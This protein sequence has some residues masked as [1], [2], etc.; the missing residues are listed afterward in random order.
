MRIHA[1]VFPLLLGLAG[2]ASTGSTM[3]AADAPR[4]LPAAG[5]VSVDWTDPA[6]FSEIAAS[7]NRSEAARGDWLNQLAVYMRESAQ[8]AL[9]DGQQLQL[10]IVDVQRAGRNEP[11]QGPEHQNIRMVRDIYPPRLTLRFRQL[12]ASGQLI[13]EGER[14]LVDSAFLMGSA[15]LRDSDPLRYEKRMVDDWVRREFGR[16]IATR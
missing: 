15:P 3:L 6:K 4:A 8:K 9:P 16:P 2:C 11:W 14:K 7:G 12:D 13:A 1:L 10:T 5:P